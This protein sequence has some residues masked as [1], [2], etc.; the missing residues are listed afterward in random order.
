MDDDAWRLGLS[1]SLRQLCHPDFD[2]LFWSAERRGAFSAWWGHV[3]FAHWI[4]RAVRPRVMVELGTHNGV[5]YSA[6]CQSVVRCQLNTRCFAVDTWEGDPHASFYGEEIYS[7]FTAYHDERFSAFSTLL[8]CTFDEAL[9]R[10]PDASVDLLHLDGL[11]T[12]DAVRRDV[13]NWLPKFSSRGVALLHDI[14]VYRDDFGVWRLWHE[15]RQQYPYFEFHHCYGLGLLAIGNDP[16]PPIGELCALQNT[17]E[18]GVLRNRVALIG[19]RWIT[20]ARE[21][22]LRTE[23]TQLHQTHA[24]TKEAL[25]RAEEARNATEQARIRTERARHQTEQALSGALATLRDANELEERFRHATAEKLQ[26][27]QSI[28]QS[29]TWRATRV[30][31][32]TAERLPQP[33]RHTLRRAAKA[34][35]WVLTP[36][37]MP[38]R[39]R[40]LR[41]RRQMASPGAPSSAATTTVEPPSVPETITV[42]PPSFPEEFNLSRPREVL[43]EPP[44]RTDLV[45]IIVCVHNALEDVRRCLSSVLECTQ[46]PYR[47][48]IVDDGSDDETRAYLADF[49]A[50]KSAVLIRNEQALGYTGAANRGL[51]TSDAPWVVLLN[52]DTI[53]TEPWLEA[54]WR[55]GW[56]DRRIGI[57]GPLSNAAS[58]QSV[59]DLSE[60]GD[61]AQNPLPSGMTPQ[62]I[63]DLVRVI[64]VGAR[65]MPFLNGFCYMIRHDVIDRVGAFDERNFSNYG[66]ENDYSIRTRNAGYRLVAATDAYVFH[67]SSKSYSPERRRSLEDR[68]NKA[69]AAKHDAPTQIAPQVEY[70]Q[71]NLVFTSVRARVRAALHQR[72]LVDSGRQSFAGKRVAF[73]LPVMEYGGGANVIFQE[74]KSLEQMG[75]NVTILNLADNHMNISTHGVPDASVRAFADVV[76]LQ[77]HLTQNTGQ[78]DAVIATHFETLYWLPPNRPPN[79]VY[80]YYIQDFEPLFFSATEPSY[81]RALE[82]YTLR[83][84]LCLMTKT[85]WN[86]GAVADATGRVPVVIGCSVN[87]DLFAPAEERALLQSNQPLRIV[88][89]LRPTSLY[90]APART[91]AALTEV[92]RRFENRV[93]VHSFGASDEQLARERLSRAW[94]TNHGHL[95]PERVA[96]LF[97]R[98]DLF[99]DFSD[100]Q[101]MGLS[102]LEAMSSGCAVIGPVAG[103]TNSFLRDRTNGLLVDTSSIDDCVEKTVSLLEDATFRSSL[104]QRAINDAS[105]HLPAAAALKMLNTLFANS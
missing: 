54:M 88:A 79:C 38:E 26:R 51:R 98:C 86:Q 68:A 35:Y 23:L 61:W 78:Y 56:R 33:L 75:L 21:H 76:A 83:D 42:E 94:I 37:R 5:S 17:D 45:D 103:G 69:L 62:D 102:L 58:W 101:A 34:G 85:L 82:S 53:V 11:H 48:I 84:D 13:E 24:L 96:A 60:A 41:N 4:M 12:Y 59:P 73:I 81:R 46:S 9:E 64:A 22:D 91:V 89:M 14:N 57:I 66:E 105:I 30:L 55:H 71:T 90:R 2:P 44:E 19:D 29:T 95:R 27:L 52:S 63:G 7:D 10:I 39:I 99:V 36:H 47:L 92:V 15:L 104:Q 28:E 77:N 80:G 100:Y 97:G 49:A 67:A 70:C 87:F 74:T 32:S 20:A 1:T 16:P 65:E 50:T 25:S 3:P 18:G 6:F 31:R 72:Q 43:S 8:R 40:F 93:R